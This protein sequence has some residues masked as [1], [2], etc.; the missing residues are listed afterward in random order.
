MGEVD[1]A[2][3][4]E[5]EHRP[6]IA[7]AAIEDRGIPSIDLSDD[8]KLEDVVSDIGNACRDWGFFQVIN[9]GVPLEKLWKVQE[10]AKK[11]F[12]QSTEEKKKVRRDEA[13]VLGYYETEHTKNVRDWKEVFDI[14]GQNPTVMYKSPETEDT[15]VTHWNNKWPD[16]PS[17]LR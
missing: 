16:Y 17:E 4:Q 3:I 2:F 9:H 5:L 13:S 12:A 11:F 8:R 7:A 10:A 6:K 1:P 14:V 15:E